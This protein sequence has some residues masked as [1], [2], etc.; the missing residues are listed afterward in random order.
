MR[1]SEPLFTISVA[2]RLC[3]LEVHTIRWIESQELIR[4]HRTPGNTRMF[5]EED[6]ERLREIAQLLEA[7]VNA[8]G[9]RMILELRRRMK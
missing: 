4:P 9:I 3:E 7:E 2:A 1:R 8:A 5:C 6:I